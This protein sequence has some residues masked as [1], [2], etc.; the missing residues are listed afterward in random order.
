VDIQPKADLNGSPHLGAAAMAQARS[1]LS[2]DIFLTL[3]STSSSS[4]PTSSSTS[5]ATRIKG[6][7]EEVPVDVLESVERN[8]GDATGCHMVNGKDSHSSSSCE[9]DNVVLARPTLEYILLPR[10]KRGLVLENVSGVDA[11]QQEIEEARDF[12]NESGAQ[13]LAESVLS[14][15]GHIACSPLPSVMG[16]LIFA[17]TGSAIPCKYRN[18]SGICL[19]DKFGRHMLLDVGE[20][21]I[22]QLLRV[23]H[24]DRDSSKQSLLSS[25]TAVWISHPHADHHLGILRLLEERQHHHHQQQQEMAVSNDKC[26]SDPVVIIAPPPIFDFLREYSLI[27]PSIANSY[28]AIDCRDFLQNQKMENSADALTKLQGAFQV[29]GCRSVQVQHCPFSFAVIL[30]GTSFGTLVYSGDCRPSH[31]LAKEARGADVL[32]HEATFEDGMEAEAALKRHCTVG[33][34]LR[35]AQEMQTKCLVLTHFSQR[36]PKIPPTPAT[37]SSIPIIFAFDF[38]RLTPQ[39]L[40]AASKLTPALRLLYLSNADDG[41]EAATEHGPSEAELALAVPGLFAQSNLL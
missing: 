22:G 3:S 35:V 4:S 25:I 33:E 27:V 40:L 11:Q 29:T 19:T 9:N 8:K 6:I 18:V 26:N 30:E 41:M 39:N 7:N 1:M 14:E 2:S 28:H 31:A 23:H 21:T 36:Y 12:A 10:S 38:M 15:C 32:I 17:G 16:Q 5:S 34:A 20:G 24:H 37:S 13:S